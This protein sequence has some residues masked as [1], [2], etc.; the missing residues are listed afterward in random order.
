MD[1]VRC[2]CEVEVDDEVRLCR[3]LGFQMDHVPGERKCD[4]TTGNFYFNLKL[5]KMDTLFFIV[6]NS[7]DLKDV[8]NQV[9]F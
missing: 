1:L 7:A 2:R 6:D 4:F 9:N 8:S 5:R 3:A